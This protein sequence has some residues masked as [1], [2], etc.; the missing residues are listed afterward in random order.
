MQPRD[1][2]V[3]IRAVLAGGAEVFRPLGQR[4]GQ[5]VPERRRRPSGEP[6]LP[7]GELQDQFGTRRLSADGFLDQPPGDD[8]RYPLW[9]SVVTSWSMVG[10]FR[11]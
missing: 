1:D 5:L 7:V 4:R 8:F 9:M 10:R 6:P 2:V 11:I 3:A